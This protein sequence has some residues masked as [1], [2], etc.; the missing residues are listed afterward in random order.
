MAFGSK[1]AIGK[2]P[3]EPAPEPESIEFAFPEHKTRY[4]RLANL[5]FGRARVPDFS[6]HREV[7]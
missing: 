2:R 4:E 7:Q 1:W 6:S 3:R 5:K